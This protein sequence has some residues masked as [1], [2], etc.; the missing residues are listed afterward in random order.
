VERSP[1][2]EKIGRPSPTSGRRRD[3]GRAGGVHAL[4]REDL[5]DRDRLSAIATSLT[6]TALDDAEAA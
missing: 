6:T 1:L 4:Q 3:R 2:L 5:R